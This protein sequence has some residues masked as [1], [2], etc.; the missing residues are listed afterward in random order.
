MEQPSSQ[1]RPVGES[2]RP[3][4]RLVENEP[5]PRSARESQPAPYEPSIS[6]S[7]PRIDTP[8]H[9]P[10][11]RTGKSS[12]VRWIAIG[13]GILLLLFVM[14]RAPRRHRENDVNRYNPPPDQGNSQDEPTQNSIGPK[15]AEP[16]AP[17]D[18]KPYEVPN[19]GIVPG[20]S[21]TPDE[22]EGKQ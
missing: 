13:V 5:T 2:T 11:P 15:R 10:A 17:A 4:L 18:L 12:S 9:T 8:A 22:G 16:E 21:R 19:I 14:G 3:A 7:F 6:R 1:S 20:N